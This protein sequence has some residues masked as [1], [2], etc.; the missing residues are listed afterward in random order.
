MNAQGNIIVW[1]SITLF[2]IMIVTGYCL[3]NYNGALATLLRIFGILGVLAWIVG[4]FILANAM[5]TDI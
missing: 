1:G 4:A 5:N 3:P 2:I